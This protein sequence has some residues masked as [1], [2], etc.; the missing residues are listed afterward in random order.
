MVKVSKRQCKCKLIAFISCDQKL[1][2]V[3]VSYRQSWGKIQMKTICLLLSY[4]GDCSFR[5]GEEMVVFKIPVEHNGGNVVPA[6]G[7]IL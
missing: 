2:K 1:N 5:P 7:T 6:L 3:L 4:S